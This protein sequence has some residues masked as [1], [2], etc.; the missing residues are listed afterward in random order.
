MVAAV[1]VTGGAVTA[2]AY[3]VVERGEDRYAGQVMDRY[4][5][6]L[7]AAVSDRT[8]RY[9][10][11]VGDLAAA[12]GAQSDL[13]AADFARMT[14]TLDT[15]RL[16]GAAGV[17]FVV[18]ATAEQ[19][20]GLQRYWRDHGASG[21][22]LQPAKGAVTHDFVV[23]EHTFDSVNDVAGIDLTQRPQVTEALRTARASGRPAISPAFRLIR[24]RGLDPGA[25]QTSV[26]FAAPVFAGL[27]SAAPDR[28]QGWI[29]LPVRGQ[30]FLAQTLL[31]RG[32]GA[33]QAGLIDAGTVLA[34]VSPGRRVPGEGLMRQR[35]LSVGQR[36]WELSL[37]P[38]TR[39]LNATDRGMSRFS[40]AAGVALTLLL[41]LM[42]AVL[43]GS[44]NRALHQVDQATTALRHDIARREDVEARLRE[45]EHELR[46]LAFHDPLTGLANRMLFHDRLTHAVATHA[47][48]GR[49]L[50]VLFLDLD[51]FKLVNDRLGHQAGDTVLRTVAERLRLS[52]RTADTVARFGGDEFAVILEDVTSAADA[53]AVAERIITGVQA[54]IDVTGTPA[55]VSTSIGIAVSRAGLTADDLI[56]Q[57]DT[58]MYAAKTAGKN[59]YVAS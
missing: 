4:A 26:A 50:A 5:A 32:Q 49:P 27:G 36:H 35:G 44:R 15:A 56:R 58:A 37:W 6:D 39:L 30:D 9:S 47:R 48:T 43:N 34:S 54:P 57:A 40:L 11:T 3:D 53:Q 22:T 18:P 1:L 10:E 33:V 8:S 7:S 24:D 28:F 13:R 51:G 45:R 21:L 25:R 23:F 38:T 14:A 20:A 17:S 52:V 16:P 59:R 2:A 19:V 31:D 29:V 42:T 46:H 41:C 55:H 12:V